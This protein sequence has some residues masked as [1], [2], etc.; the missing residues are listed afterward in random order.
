MTYPLA[1]SYKVFVSSFL[2]RVFEFLYF[3]ALGIAYSIRHFFGWIYQ[4]NPPWV[5]IC[6]VLF[7]IL[8]MLNFTIAYW[9]ESGI[10]DTS[11]IYQEI[12]QIN[13][14][15]SFY[16]IPDTFHYKKHV[17]SS[18]A[19]EAF[20]IDKFAKEQFEEQHSDLTKAFEAAALNRFQLERY[21][22]ALHKIN[23]PLVVADWPKPFRLLFEGY[24]KQIYTRA[25]LYPNI[26]PTYML[27]VQLDT[28]GGRVHKKKDTWCDQVYMEKLYKKAKKI[29]DNKPMS[30]VEK[31]FWNEV[32]GFDEEYGY[33]YTE[34]QGKRNSS[35]NTTSSDVSGNAI[36]PKLRYD[37]LTRDHHRCVRCGKSSID[38][39]VLDVYPKQL[40]SAG[41]TYTMSNLRTLCDSCAAFEAAPKKTAR[42]RKVNFVSEEF[43]QRER[44]KMTPALKEQIKR[45]DGYHCVICGKGIEHGTTLEVDHIKPIALGGLSTPSN[46]RTLCYDCNRGKGAT[47]DPDGIN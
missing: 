4:L 47:Y 42:A 28:P 18:A 13:R 14:T 38:G 20:T 26:N 43:K 21:V 32:S 39:V 29:P 15:Y 2:E 5:I 45:R 34:P 11:P 36:S 10:K 24:E 19:F 25:M 12:L 30:S 16:K 46:L 3:S 23:H 9:F 31:L 37:V 41:R 33:T 1:I 27:L 17:S 40:L 6:V 8:E 7:I 22:H 44:A 35:Q